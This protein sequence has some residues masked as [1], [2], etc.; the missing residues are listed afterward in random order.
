MHIKLTEPFLKNLD[1]LQKNERQSV[2]SVVIQL[3]YALKRGAHEHGG[4]SIRKIH[5]TGVFEARVDLS[6]RIVFGIQE[7]EI[8]IHK[9]GNHD[10]IERYI[11]TL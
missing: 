5:Q 6:L 7:N 4:L 1:K 9:I 8:L 2:L 11:K 10:D 3:P